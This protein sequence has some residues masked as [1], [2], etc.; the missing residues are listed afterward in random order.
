ALVRAGGAGRGSG[1]DSGGAPGA[2]LLE[3]EPTLE[4]VG[5]AAAERRAESLAIGAE[6]EALKAR[7]RADQR[8]VTLIADT[9][10]VAQRRALAATWSAY[11]TGSTDLAGVL[12][13]AHASYNEELTA[14]RT[15]EDLAVTLARLLI[16]SARPAL[17][18]L[19]LPAPDPSRRKP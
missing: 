13:A 19:D 9:V 17:V 8:T 4:G 12:D 10:L 16:M 6:I 3:E 1:G 15:R 5:A 18:G 2:S 7:A 11:E 14:V